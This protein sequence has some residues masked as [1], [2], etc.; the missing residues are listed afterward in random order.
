MYSGGAVNIWAKLG[1]IPVSITLRILVG[2]I[3]GC[4]L[5]RLFAKFNWQPPKRTLIVLG[6]AIILTL[7]ETLEDQKTI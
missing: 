4:F 7:L 5:Y 2:I 1:E 3:S 6:V